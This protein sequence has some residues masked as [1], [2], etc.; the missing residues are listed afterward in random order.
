M[1]F[2]ERGLRFDQF[3]AVGENCR[4]SSRIDQQ[5]TKKLAG[6]IM[7]TKRGNEQ[8]DLKRRCQSSPAKMELAAGV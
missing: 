2:G 8:V 5:I 1:S 6:S 3:T 7:R 4:Y